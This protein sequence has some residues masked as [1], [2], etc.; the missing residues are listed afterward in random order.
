MINIF[1]KKNEIN[2]FLLIAYKGKKLLKSKLIDE[3]FSII[4][5]NNSKDVISQ[6]NKTILNF[7]N[8][9]GYSDKATFKLFLRKNLLDYIS[10]LKK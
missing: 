6:E 7:F 1:I 9:S 3:Y 2:E 5:N 4:S 10:K 8:F